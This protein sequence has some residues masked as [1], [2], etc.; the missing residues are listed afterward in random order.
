VPGTLTFF[1]GQT[2][3]Q[4]RVPVLPGRRRERNETFTLR[5]SSPAGATFA[6]ARGLAT[7]VDD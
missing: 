2:A 1:A 6:D 7:I 5:L 4:V 3:K